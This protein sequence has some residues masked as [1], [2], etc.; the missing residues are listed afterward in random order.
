M[1]PYTALLL[2][3]SAIMRPVVAK[4]SVILNLN[5]AMRSTDAWMPGFSVLHNLN[6]GLP[7]MSGQVCRARLTILEVPLQSYTYFNKKH[8]LIGGLNADGTFNNSVNAFDN[9]S[10]TAGA[11][12]NST[13]TPSIAAPPLSL[14]YA[15]TGVVTARV[16]TANGSALLVCGQPVAMNGNQCEFLVAESATTKW[17]MVGIC[18]LFVLITF[19]RQRTRRTSVVCGTWTRLWP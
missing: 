15:S 4:S 16:M 3:V 13:R 14:A 6:Y 7:H 5:G 18:A 10:V 11:L 2:M 19:C 8:Y 9:F 12:R 1:L 17:Q